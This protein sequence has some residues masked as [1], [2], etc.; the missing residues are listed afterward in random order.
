M[1]ATAIQPLGLLG[2]GSF[3]SIFRDLANPGSSTQSAERE[4]EL[5]LKDWLKQD[6]PSLKH[7]QSKDH[8]GQLDWE[9]AIKSGDYSSDYLKWWLDR[10]PG[11]LREGNLPGGGGI[12]DQIS[13]AADPI[14][15]PSS[16]WGKSREY[17]GDADYVKARQEGFSDL[18]IR[19]HLDKNPD[20]L[21]EGNVP[22]GGGLYDRIAES[23][24]IPTEFR[25][26]Q[27]LQDAR[28]EAESFEGTRPIT[29]KE[30]GYITGKASPV[31][32]G[33][34]HFFPRESGIDAAASYGNRATDDFQGRF[35][36]GLKAQA[37]VNALEGGEALGH[38]L[39][40]FIGKVPTLGDPKELYEYYA[41]K[42]ESA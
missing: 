39:K 28:S 27:D 17:F 32:K 7:G 29:V 24:E 40:R 1:P 26:S 9:E 14:P 25:P 12:Y 20:L 16:K 21:R 3:S 15:M 30:A 4:A 5:Q 13:Q 11:V 33:S 2:S 35:V 6:P 22:G 41:D 23:A 8:F 38:H 31:P 34:I 37:K 36:P 10:N 19:S 18:D 42:V